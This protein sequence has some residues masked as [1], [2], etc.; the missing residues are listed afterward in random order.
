MS[1]QLLTDDIMK[2]IASNLGPASHPSWADEVG[3]A[4][5]VRAEDAQVA[6]LRVDVI[7]HGVASLLRV[8]LERAGLER[9]EHL[10]GLE[11]VLP[12]LHEAVD[13]DVDAYLPRA[14][15]R[16]LPAARVGPGYLPTLGYKSYAMALAFGGAPEST[17]YGTDG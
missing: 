2:E 12:Q 8:R 3:A 10:R 14:V 5:L 7:H 1:M 15:V 16:H 6:L 4:R 11:R 17:S 9:L 13:V